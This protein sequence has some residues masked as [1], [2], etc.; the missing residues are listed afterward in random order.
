[1][2]KGETPDIRAALSPELW[3][4]ALDSAAQN[5]GFQHFDDALGDGSPEVMVYLMALANAQLPDDHPMKITRP[6]ITGLRN[7]LHRYLEQDTFSP[8]DPNEAQSREQRE[9]AYSKGVHL[10]HA[11]DKLL[12]PAGR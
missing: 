8:D 6:A 2:P 5:G 12:P 3:R 9:D 4:R 10:L 11:L 1:M 7:F